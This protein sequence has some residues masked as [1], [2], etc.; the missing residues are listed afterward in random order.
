M[1]ILLNKIKSLGTQ[2][3]LIKFLS[4]LL[5]AK[6]GY[7][8]QLQLCLRHRRYDT[9]NNV[10]DFPLFLL[11][12]QI[13]T[14]YSIDVYIFINLYSINMYILFYIMYCIDNELLSSIARYRRSSFD[15]QPLKYLY[16]T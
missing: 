15:M 7:G 5:T 9:S 2:R 4:N 6:D 8:R 10:G 14:H 3:D 12:G 13:G 16:K 11:K 1:D